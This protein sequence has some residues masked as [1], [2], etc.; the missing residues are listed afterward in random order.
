MT[1]SGRAADPETISLVVTRY[2]GIQYSL[3]QSYFKN[4]PGKKKK[5]KYD[6]EENQQTCR[7]GM[8]SLRVSQS[9]SFHFFNAFHV[10]GLTDPWNKFWESMHAF[11][12]A[13]CIIDAKA[14][15]TFHPSLCIVGAKTLAYL[16]D[17]PNALLMQRHLHEFH[18]SLCI[19]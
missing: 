10:F 11:C 13:Q 18:P 9:R 14:I 3:D 16:F 15:H 8:Q 2:N 17:L 5:R 19:C 7:H 1:G 6:N 12:P 4:S